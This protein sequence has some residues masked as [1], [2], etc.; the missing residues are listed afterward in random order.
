VPGSQSLPGQTV[1]L[2]L[3]SALLLALLL[4]LAV[5]AGSPA[6]AANQALVDQ[7]RLRWESSP[8]GPMLARILP[9]WDGA[10]GLPD[11]A[12]HGAW[13]TVRYC[14]QCHHLPNPAMHDRA[15]WAKVVDRMVARMR[16]QGN[17]GTLMKDMMAGV[18]AP[19]EEEHHALLDYLQRHAQRQLDPSRHPDLATRGRAFRDACSQC[20]VLPDPA[21]H[22]ARDWPGVVSRMERNMAWMNRVVGSRPDPR[23]PQ[24]RV[25]DIVGYLQANAARP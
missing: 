8:H 9:P 16:G 10:A 3:P 5:R 13:L 22:R 1:R 25:E 14:S 18:Q 23:E 15:R 24:L 17:M 6:I 4:P 12:S 2:G 7:A 20:H 11:P 19:N 21:A